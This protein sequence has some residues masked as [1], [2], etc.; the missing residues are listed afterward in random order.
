M[1]SFA[2]LHWSA[3]KELEVIYLYDGE[4]T[5]LEFPKLLI[6]ISSLS[7][8]CAVFE[9]R[10][11][12]AILSAAF[13]FVEYDYIYSNDVEQSAR[14]LEGTPFDQLRSVDHLEALPLRAVYS[15]AAGV[16]HDQLTYWLADIRDHG[17][18]TLTSEIMYTLSKIQ[19]IL[20][21]ERHA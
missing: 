12:A 5:Y 7:D 16:L 6:S 2:Y 3:Q 10:S 13:D 15:I 20:N 9:T 4:Y 17:R 1:K 11:K 19:S 18:T 21:R 14:F 8:A